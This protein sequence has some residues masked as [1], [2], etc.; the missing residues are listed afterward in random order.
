MCVKVVD[1]LARHKHRRGRRRALGVEGGVEE[2]DWYHRKEID[3]EPKLHVVPRYL[4]EAGL[5]VTL[6][7]LVGRHEV[8]YDV[9]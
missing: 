6:W 3:Q 4:S 2:L 7:R 5:Q 9:D 1:V 8:Q